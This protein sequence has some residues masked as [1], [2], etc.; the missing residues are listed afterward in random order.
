MASLQVIVHISRLR[1]TLAAVFFD[2]YLFYALVTGIV[3]D[4]LTST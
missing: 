4:G 1:Q 3:L 2:L